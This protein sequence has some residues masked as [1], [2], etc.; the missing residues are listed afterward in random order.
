MIVVRAGLALVIL[1]ACSRTGLDD[2]RP[3]PTTDGAV[4]VALDTA[5]PA[6]V[7][8]EVVSDAG[9]CDPL[10]LVDGSSPTALVLDGD[11]VY[12]SGG[13]S[14]L[15]VA[16]V[17]KKGGK[18]QALS[19][20]WSYDIAVDDTYVYWTWPVGAIGSV[21]RVPKAGG[22]TDI[23]ASW[24]GG[25]EGIAVDATSIYVGDFARIWKIAKS[26]ASVT[27]IS[28]SASQP[29]RLAVLDSTL[30]YTGWTT[31]LGRVGIDGSNPAVVHPGQYAEYLAVEPGFV[32]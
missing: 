22:N 26:D 20:T 18:V 15:S 6:D 10:V 11:W 24:Q 23:F 29:L 30:Y 21:R 19:P 14:F 3:I 12:F 7:T 9:P 25:A 16:R 31:G 32:F 4:D 5:P 1:T 28:S 17:P 8:E 2:S 13:G 27:A